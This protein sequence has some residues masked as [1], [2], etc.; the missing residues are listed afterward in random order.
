MSRCAA[1]PRL[2]HRDRRAAVA[3][4]AGAVA[5]CS[6]ERLADH[7]RRVLGRVMRTGLEI[8]GDRDVEIQRAVP[9]EKVEHVVQEPHAGA[10]LAGSGA[11][12]CDAHVDLRLSGIA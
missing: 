2:V 8:P 5:E 6:V 1:R 9:R 3:A 4:D 11:F 12:E 7:D 10:P